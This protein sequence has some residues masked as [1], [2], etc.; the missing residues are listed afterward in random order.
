[1]LGP[2]YKEVAVGQVLGV[3]TNTNG[4]F[5][6]SM[7][8]ENFGVPAANVQILTGLTYN[9]TDA[10]A[11]YSVGE[12][13]SG[14]TLNTTSGAVT[15]GAT[16]GYSRTIAAG[17]QTIS[18]SGGDLAAMVSMT[19]TITAGTNALVNL[20]G[21]STVETSTSLTA[22]SGVSRIIG[23]GNLGLSLTGSDAA[24]F[25]V[26]ALGNDALNG[27][28]GFDTAVFSGNRSSYTITIHGAG[29][30]T[31]SGP[32]GTDTVAAIELL[33]FSDMSVAL[34]S[35]PV[36]TID[37]HSVEINVFAHVASWLSY[38]DADGSAA[39][40]YQFYDG[41]AAANSGYFWSPANPHHPADTYINVA[42]ADV[43]GVWVRGGQWP[44]PKPCGCARSTA[45]TGARGMPLR[46]ARTHARL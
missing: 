44:V 20:I 39:M 45:P 26:S 46:S 24:N 17:A 3:F 11:F 14:I 1:M 23:L 18:F 25:I 31:V 5:N 29:S 8:T 34:R 7:V 13:R 19:A 9:D 37:N 16:G 2:D 35:A 28:G 15:T 12:G 6:A 42:A 22:G 27:A 30:A 32:D 4:S 10:D 33:Q 43:G 38:S 41:G 40:Q 21:Q 36:A